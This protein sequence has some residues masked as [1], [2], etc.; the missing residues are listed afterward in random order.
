MINKYGFLVAS[1]LLLYASFV[2]AA[3]FEFFDQQSERNL[4]IVEGLADDWSIVKQFCNSFFAVAYSA[5]PQEEREFET[6]EALVNQKFLDHYPRI[7]DQQQYKFFLVKDNDNIIGY[8]IFDVIDDCVYEIETQADI[9]TYSINSLMTGLAQFISKH[10][11]PQAKYFV[12]ATRKSVPMYGYLLEL[13][14]FKLSDKLH[15]SIAHSAQYY[16]DTSRGDVAKYYQG[17]EREL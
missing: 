11:A 14:G 16:G 12:G 10:I 17:Y 7:F 2:Q 9:N 8:T 3:P 13:C 15:P 1:V 6:V 5:I 4:K